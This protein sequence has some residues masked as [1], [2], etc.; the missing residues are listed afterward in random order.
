[1]LKLKAKRIAAHTDR[2]LDRLDAIEAAI[3]AL[4]TDDL[5]DFADIFAGGDPTPLRKIAEAA[6]K[7]RGI[8][9]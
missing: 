3:A 9:L 5:L 6:M 4:D 7:R 2:A 1:M 8:S